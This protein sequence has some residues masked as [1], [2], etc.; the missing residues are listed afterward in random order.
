MSCR[1]HLLSQGLSVIG[2]STGKYHSLGPPPSSGRAPRSHCMQCECFHAEQKRSKSHIGQRDS[3]REGTWLGTR[4]CALGCMCG[5][6][7]SFFSHCNGTLMCDVRSRDTFST[8]E[9]RCVCTSQ[10]YLSNSGTELF[11]TTADIC[12]GNEMRFLE[13][14]FELSWNDQSA[15]HGRVYTSLCFWS[16]PPGKSDG[17]DAGNLPNKWRLTHSCL[18]GG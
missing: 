6:S 7:V 16:G 14:H 1:S 2:S 17:A 18:I 5:C 9:R 8:S 4:I 15:H 11:T 12:T 3:P 10:Q 13:A